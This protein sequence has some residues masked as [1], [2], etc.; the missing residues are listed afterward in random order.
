MAAD[1]EFQVLPD[2]AE[3]IA[4][5]QISRRLNAR[6]YRQLLRVA[7]GRPF[8]DFVSFNFTRGTPQDQKKIWA[9]RRRRAAAS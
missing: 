7:H 2:R 9:T 4:E 3:I 6:K 8:P 5:V 1:N